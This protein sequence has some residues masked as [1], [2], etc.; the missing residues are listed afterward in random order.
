MC[1]SDLAA[2]GQRDLKSLLIPL[3]PLDEQRRIV[4]ILNRAAKI[5]R[6]RARARE[7]L[8]EFIPALFIQMFGDPV[9]NPYGYHQQPL[10]EC[11][12]FISGATPGKQNRSYWDGEIPWISPK[13]MK[14]DLISDSEYRVSNL[15][16]AETSL[17]A[18]PANTPI[19]V[20]RGMI[21]AHTVPIALT[22]RTVA[23]NQ[24]IKA[25]DFDSAIEPEFGFWCLKA[26]H[27]RILDEVDTAAHGTK[28]IEISRLGGIPMHIPSRDEQRR[29]MQLVEKALST[30][31][32][33]EVGFRTASE[34]GP[35]LMS[36]LQDY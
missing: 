18:V 35:A 22:T 32:I 19:I 11:A 7:R 33:T 26:L 3:P 12:N 28:R 36:K 25:I 27:Q 8:R 6:L 9:E 23:I 21:L 5:V 16:F 4:G 10:S 17:K 31:A 20:V 13:D 30:V 14:V 29:Y 15:A 34:L 2:I 24:D 1:S